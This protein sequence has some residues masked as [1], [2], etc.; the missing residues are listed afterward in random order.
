MRK[1]VRSGVSPSVP[2]L[3]L[4]N[5]L[6]FMQFMQFVLVPVLVAVGLLAFYAYQGALDV[7]HIVAV[8]VFLV[9]AVPVGIF[10]YRL[11]Q[12]LRKR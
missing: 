11:S 2:I 1:R 9:I 10:G 7:E 4:M 8:V 12:K 5:R 3:G 6:Q